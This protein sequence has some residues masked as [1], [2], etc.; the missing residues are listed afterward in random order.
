MKSWQLFLGVFV[1]II[2]SVVISAFTLN[3]FGFLGATG[4]GIITTIGGGTI[5]QGV[6]CQLAPSLVTTD[7]DILTPG[8]SITPTANYRYNGAFA[9]TTAPTF[10]TVADILFNASTYINVI[11]TGVPLDCGANPVIIQQYSLAN[12]TLSVYSNDGLTKLTN[13]AA[14]GAY[15][16]TAAAA[17][18]SYN[19]RIHFQGTDKKSTGEQLVILET[20]SPTNVSSASLSGATDVEVPNGYTRQLTNGYAKAWVI[21]AVTGNIAIDHNLA[22]A[23]STSTLV[24]GATYIT[25]YSLQPFS[26]TD[27]AFITPGVTRSSTTGSVLTAYNSINTAKYATYQ[28][29][30]FLIK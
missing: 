8:T 10:K 9:G 15:N 17:G 14:G 2:V 4:G 7:T 16:E 3:A 22:V 23:S 24:Q 27:G 30:N 20:T 13:A 1:I 6:G 21:P 28:T 5:Q 26:D 18:G 12:A 25:V 11:K 29:Y 19:W